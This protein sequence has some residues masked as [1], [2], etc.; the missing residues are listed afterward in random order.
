M[1]SVFKRPTTLHITK[2]RYLGVVLNV[3][4]ESKTFVANSVVRL[5]NEWLFR[6]V[7][8]SELIWLISISPYLTKKKRTKKILT[9]VK[10]QLDY[11][12]LELGVVSGITMN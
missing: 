2:Y 5:E 9:L 11:L 4:C 10:L 3:F 8:F 6:T 12:K 1:L 7:L